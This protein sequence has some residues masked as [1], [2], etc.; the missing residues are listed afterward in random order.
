VF[1]VIFQIAR[2]VFAITW[3]A[4]FRARPV[5]ECAAEPHLP[6]PEAPSAESLRDGHE[7]SDAKP[8][9]VAI[10]A[11]SLFLVIFATMAVLGWMY[12]R[13]Y[14]RSSAMPVPALQESFKNGPFVRTSI[15]DDWAVIDAQSHQRLDGYHWKDRAAGSVQIPIAQAMKLVVREGLPSRNGPTPF[16]PPPAQEKLPVGESEQTQK[17]RNPYAP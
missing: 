11:I 6:D 17:A 7:L 12:K 8:R 4:V 1:R 16:F 14:S 13:F 3:A 10:L 15:E 9:I 5:T 2:L